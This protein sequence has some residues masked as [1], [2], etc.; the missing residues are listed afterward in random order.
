MGI[1]YWVDW[2][3]TTYTSQVQRSLVR[4]YW[5]GN[6]APLTRTLDQQTTLLI[7]SSLVID[8]GSYA[9]FQAAEQG[10]LRKIQYNADNSTEI[11]HFG[12]ELPRVKAGW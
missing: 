8:I 3:A 9:I 5:F 1:P 6:A 11:I 10:L 12:V 2:P 4:S 7:L